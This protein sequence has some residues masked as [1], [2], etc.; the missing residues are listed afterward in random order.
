MMNKNY[1]KDKK[2]LVVGLGS[3]GYAAACLASDL[4][5]KVSVTERDINETIQIYADRLKP[6][7]VKL[8]L[9]R[10]SEPF[11]KDNDLVILSPGV[12]NKSLPVIWADSYNI[13]MIS[14]IE[15]AWLVCPAKIIAITGTNG[16]STVT[17]LI[18]EV[19][20]RAN[21]RV[22]VCGNIGNP[23]SGEVRSMQAEDYVSL[24]V[25]SF[26]LERIQT[27]KP[28][29]SVILNFTTDHL[30]RYDNIE[31]YLEAKKRIF[32][33]QT[34]DDYV[35]LNHADPIL[36]D[37]VKEINANT[38]YFNTSSKQNPN[39]SAITAVA[40]ILGI[41][42]NI[43]DEAFRNFKGLEHRLEY[44]AALNN[45]EF[46]NDSKATNVDSTLWALENIDKPIILIAG[47]KDKGL[48]FDIIKDLL[49]A[50]VKCLILIGEI[51]Q[52]LREEFKD[53]I[54]DIYESESLQEAV[55]LA[56]SK[57]KGR[58]CILLSPMCSSFDMFS[59][60]EDRG[61]VFKQAVRNLINSHE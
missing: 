59:N 12:D 43:A 2:V 17:T 5:A 30:D 38:V 44:V 11:V 42:M 46:I 14:E 28:K 41:D 4:G 25:S 34:E 49:R 53:M 7:H 27:F 35:V 22:H 33:N 47:G 51:K 57:A 1:F 21:M 52:R 20:K 9:G 23:F 16:K 50:K 58:D 45:I 60:F 13:P 32:M 31:G 18:G 36:R 54:V 3:S 48:K 56:Y 40:D 26:Q 39:Y 6:R 8:Q 19:L 29:I 61:S 55:R 10:H 37:L 15:L 24:E